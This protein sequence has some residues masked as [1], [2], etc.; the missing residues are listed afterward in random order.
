MSARRTESKEGIDVWLWS[1]VAVASPDTIIVPLRD[2]EETKRGGGSRDRFRGNPKAVEKTRIRPELVFSVKKGCFLSLKSLIKR[3][4]PASALAVNECRIH[5][6]MRCPVMGKCRYRRMRL[7]G[8]RRQNQRR[9]V[10]ME[11]PGR[12][13]ICSYTPLPGAPPPLL[14]T[15]I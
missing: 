8:I 3:R 5:T 7:V 6:S 1:H 2:D 9:H 13:Y 14:H 11:D 10:Q 15:S 12:S 4:G